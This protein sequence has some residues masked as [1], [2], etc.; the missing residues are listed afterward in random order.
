MRRRA[1][2]VARRSHWTR[3]SGIRLFELASRGFDVWKTAQWGPSDCMNSNAKKLHYCKKSFFGIR[4]FFLLTRGTG[5]VP[6]MIRMSLD[7][8]CGFRLM[9]RFGKRRVLL[10]LSG[11]YNRYLGRCVR[12]TSR[13]RWGEEVRWRGRS[14]E[15]RSGSLSRGR[16]RFKEGTDN[17]MMRFDDEWLDGAS[18]SS[19]EGPINTPG[20]LAQDLDPL[21][22]GS[23]FS[24]C[25]F[26]RSFPMS[27]E[28]V[29]SS[30]VLTCSRVLL[31]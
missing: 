9:F 22:A 27:H 18:E 15:E 28:L 6:K 24:R 29:Y 7:L 8:F 3:H 21:S 12:G 19:F 25:G 11:D 23:S 5:I 2:F 30:W 16:S 31:S 10:F 20:R 14:V 13:C 1:Q 4:C 26:R 17:L